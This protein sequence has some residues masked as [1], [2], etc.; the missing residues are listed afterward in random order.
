MSIFFVPP[1]HVIEEA[2][3]FLWEKRG[4]VDGYDH[5]D[6]IMAERAAVFQSNYEQVD[7]FEFVTPKRRYLGPNENR[8]CR[9]C[10][11]TDPNKFKNDSHAI[12][13]LLGNK[14]VIARYECDDCNGYFSREIE[15]DLGK[16]L[17]GGRTVLGIRGSSGI[18]SY[19]T[20]SKQSRMDRKADRLDVKETVGDRFTQINPDKNQVI[21]T[22][23]TQAFIP[24]AVYKS[25]AKIAL[26]L[27]P[28]DELQY[29]KHAIDFVMSPDHKAD[30]AD[31]KSANCYRFFV[32]GPFPNPYGWAALFKRRD[33]R[34]ALPYMALVVATANLVFQTF[35]P[36]CLRDVHL[37][38]KTFRF[39]S[40][41]AGYGRGYDYGETQFVGMKLSSPDRQTVGVKIDTRAET[42]T[43]TGADIR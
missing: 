42:M 25:F 19:K 37:Q 28:D 23:K 14:S 12:P 29:F 40:F 15:D 32:P 35:V 13:Q 31:S 7:W 21:Y 1:R 39:P 10:G 16:C 17:Q 22:L 34:G 27:M 43:R 11:S 26:S 41:P 18:P 20:T 9:F 3:Y 24:L 36:L 33:D 2:A 6:W 4:Q 8:I 38:G 5:A 30:A